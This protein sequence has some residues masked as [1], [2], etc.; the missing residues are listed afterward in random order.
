MARNQRILSS[1]RGNRPRQARRDSSSAGARALEL[2]LCSKRTAVRVSSISRRAAPGG[3]GR[4]AQGIGDRPRGVRAGGRL[5]PEAR[6]DRPHGG[7]PAESPAGKV[8]PGRRQPGSLDYR[9]AEG[10]VPAGGAATAGRRARPGHPAGPAGTGCTRQPDPLDCR[11]RRGSRARGDRGG[12]VVDASQST[13]VDHRRAA[14]REPG[15]SGE[16]VLR[17]RPHRRNHP[18][19]L[20]H[21]GRHGPVADVIL[22][23]QGQRADGR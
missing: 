5:R 4:R 14:A 20:A 3:Q 11:R 2:R 7:R 9:P 6:R 23:D 12:V 22:C 17:G 19:P 16:R 1:S 21:R 13:G 8:L 15:R 10:R 18:Q